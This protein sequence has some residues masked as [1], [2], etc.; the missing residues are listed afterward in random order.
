MKTKKIQK[1]SLRM[2]LILLVSMLSISSMNGQ[3]RYNNSHLFIGTQPSSYNEPST[4]PSVCIGP[5]FS[6]EIFQNGLNFWRP[7]PSV[8]PA[9][10]LLYIDET[11][12]IGIGRKPTTYQLEVNGAV[13]TTSGLLITSDGTLKK[14]IVNIKAKNS[15]YISRLMNLNGKFYEKQIYSEEANAKEI[16]EMVIAGKI[17]AE[18]ADAAL[19][20]LNQTRKE[21]YK[22][23]FGFIAQEVE[24]VFPELVEKSEDGIYAINYIGLIPVMLEAIKELQTKVIELESQ[25]STSIGVLKSTEQSTNNNDMTVTTEYL[26]QNK[27]NPVNGM[28]EISYSL[29]DGTHS[30]AIIFYSTNGSIAKNVKL[31]T[32]NKTGHITISSSEFSSGLYAYKLV[33][34]GIV[35]DTKKMINK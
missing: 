20:S 13:W 21:T 1:L 23:E 19:E 18:S 5:D 24:E 10:Y 11:G 17:K 27:P 33:A 25:Q 31:N 30:A 26:S 6:I 32:S 2:A 4:S 15:D 12:K 29:P 22:K 8:N 7:W 9:N 14:N 34:N 16:G 35:L 28:A 3:L